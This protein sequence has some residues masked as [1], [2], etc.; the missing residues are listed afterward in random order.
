MAQDIRKVNNIE[1]LMSYFSEKLAWEIDPDA[2]Y[3]IDDI[4]YEFDAEDLGLKEEAFAKIASLKQ[5][6]PLVD[7]QK[8][9]IFFVEFDSRRFEVSA[10]RKILSGLVPTRRNSADHAVWDMRDLLFLCT[11]G[12]GNTVTIGAAHFEDADKGL[13]QI[14]MIS[15]EPAVEDFTQVNTFEQRLAKLQWP[16][17]PSD[18]EAWRETWS[19]AFTV[20]YR[21]VIRDAHT[22]TVRL[23]EE[24]QHIRNLILDILKIETRNGY[25][26]LLFE[27][28][29]NTLIH[30]MTEQ[31][32]AD[33]YAQTIVYGLFSARCMDGS[34]NDFSAAEAVSCIPNTNP[35]LKSLM[36]ECLSTERTSSKLS[37]D[38]LEIGNIVTLLKNTR[39]DAII[40]DFNRQTGGGREDPVIHFYEEFLTEYDKAQKVQR[41]VYYTP[42]PIVSFIVRAVD[43]ILKSEF[44]ISDGLAS[45]E[46][47]QIK[48]KRQ[49]KRKQN[50]L[51]REVEDTEEVPAIQILDPATGTGTFLRQT[52]LR[53]YQN[54]CDARKGMPK[55]QIQ[56][57]WNAY[58]PEHLLPR[59]NGFE[60]MMAPYAVAHMKLAMVLKD[61]GYDFHGD[62]RLKVYLTN[63]LEEPG[64][65]ELQ[66]NMYND[67]LAAE[68][69][70]ANAAKKN[71]GINIVMGNPPYSSSSSN[72]GEWITNL[73]AEYKKNLHEKKINLD[74]DYIKF[75][76]YGQYVV[77]KS[78]SGVLAYISN[79]SFLDGITHRTM[80]KTLLG[81]FS[82][83]YI[84]NIHGN[85]KKKE[86]SPDGS[87]DE[88]VFDIQQ[89]V[90]INIF[91]LKKS[92]KAEC[93]TIK[94]FDLYG[95][96]SYKYDWL[97]NNTLDS[98][99]FR[100]LFPVNP[101]FFFVEKD[102]SALQEYDKGISVKKLFRLYNS[103][104]QTK[105]DKLLVSFNA[106]KSTQ[107]VEDF[108]SLETDQ[109]R[110]KYNLPVDKGGWNIAAAKEDVLNSKPQ[111]VP[112]LYRPFDIR[113][114]IYTGKSSGIMGRPRDSVMSQFKHSNIGLITCR[115]Q[116]TFPFQHA[117][118]TNIMS[119][120][121]S[122][123]MQT[124]EQSFV[125][126]L[127][128]YV[129]EYDRTV[130]CSNF[131]LESVQELLHP[132]CLTFTE[133][134]SEWNSKHV[135]P[136]ALFSYIYAVLYTPNYRTKYKELLKI[137]F[138]K[139][140][141]PKSA[142]FFW[143]MA[144][145][146]NSLIR[147]H[148]MDS[149]GN[150]HLCSS[151]SCHIDDR[152][153]GKITYKNEKVFIN[154]ESYFDGVPE[155][156][157][158]FYIGGYQ[159]LQKWLKERK[160]RNI[161]DGEVLH[162]MNVVETLRLTIEIMNQLDMFWKGSK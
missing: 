104:I 13:P 24:A 111:I 58:V 39:T 63:T 130:R 11:W 161:S 149:N 94:C 128:T 114:S 22:L 152:L 68:S 129:K 26:H 154:K 160:N 50:G 5:L 41:G 87:K 42:Q 69:I 137:D 17:D 120:L 100:D 38:E 82:E 84:V 89:G 19:S 132:I 131:D 61:T 33:M 55:E 20:R 92:P 134:D 88:N 126:P 157:W 18:I 4:T 103:G 36:Q 95:S 35:F 116:T 81:L 83:I 153:I 49:S 145:A 32:F 47:K 133:T 79:N 48:I 14:K 135:N 146:G 71:N 45:T 59:L 43:D 101:N 105:C 77:E 98:I 65:S 57:E 8:W 102:F 56:Q 106:Q 75:I 46:T 66:I 115:L 138:P 155:Y 16:S 117:L 34:Q 148:L 90:S 123:S 158:T 144:E 44:G 118:V 3:D 10:L 15:C 12:N 31:Q 86:I 151:V 108:K 99:E 23:A 122:I 156:I 127:Y 124:G 119:D 143:K 110:K 162:F 159:P 9:G 136:Y 93:C 27:K 21:Q 147:L 91:V 150:D 74:D 37:F 76:R 40:A 107:I 85:A 73:V 70:E 140:P 7:N 96:R 60:L 97:Q 25:V 64:D 109:L 121:N 112:Y 2:I 139:I 141:L 52:I 54:F 80:R 62:E 53:I 125:F 67:P 142:D 29:Q 6:R 113:T 28:F 72:K 51:Y 30:D 1:S 78:Q